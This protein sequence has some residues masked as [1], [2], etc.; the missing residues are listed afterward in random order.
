VPFPVPGDLQRIDPVDHVP[1]R[2]QRSHPQA[3][4]GLDP[5]PHLGLGRLAQL[6]ADHRVQPGHPR[7]SLRQP[8]PGQRAPGLV[9]QLN[10]VM[11][12]CPVIAYQQHM[13]SRPRH[14]PVRQPAG[15]SSAT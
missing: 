12:L 8:G 5:N 13:S 3:A 6:L 7:R 15:E 14:H 9:H 10:V 1:G 4:A 11:I 2:G